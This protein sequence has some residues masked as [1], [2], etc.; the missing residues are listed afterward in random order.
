MVGCRFHGSVNENENDGENEAIIDDEVEE[1]D[2]ERDEYD[3]AVV[4]MEQR[5]LDRGEL[6]ELRGLHSM[7]SLFNLLW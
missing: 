5:L 7:M 1:I 6:K 3:D 2:K 4:S